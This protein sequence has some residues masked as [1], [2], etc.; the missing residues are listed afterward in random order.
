LSLGLSIFPP[1]SK[2]PPRLASPRLTA[3][4]L[5]ALDV[6]AIQPTNQEKRAKNK[7]LRI[8]KSNFV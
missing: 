6:G 8:A 1:A 2:L 5:P 7:R 3:P 4:I